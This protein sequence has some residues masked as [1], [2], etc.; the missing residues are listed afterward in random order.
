MEFGG[1]GGSEAV[2]KQMC[3]MV[4][5]RIVLAWVLT[6]P[7]VSAFQRVDRVQGFGLEA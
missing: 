2:V 1:G 7:L 3:T 4:P 5:P 6:I